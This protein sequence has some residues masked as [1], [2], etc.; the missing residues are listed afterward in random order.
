[1]LRFKQISNVYFSCD[2]KDWIQLFIQLLLLKSLSLFE[3][4][5]DLICM[6]IYLFLVDDLKVI[7]A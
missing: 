2:R 1:M 3:K 7:Y 5:Q 6:H 4:P